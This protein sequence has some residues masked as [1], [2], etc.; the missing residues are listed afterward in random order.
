MF[1]EFLKIFSSRK[2]INGVGFLKNHSEIKE[3][4]FPATQVSSQ[5]EYLQYLDGSIAFL[6]VVL[7]I[8]AYQY[9]NNE[10]IIQ[11][12]I[13]ISVFG[14]IAIYY[15]TKLWRISNQPLAEDNNI[16]AVLMLNDSGKVIRQWDIHGKVSLLIGK[17]KK[18][19]DV[20]IDLS[21]SMYDA[22]IY[23]E[24]AVLNYARNNWYLEGLHVPSNVS[25]RKAGDQVR[26]RLTGS[27]PC[28]LASGDIIYI[29]NTRLM[30]K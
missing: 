19:K 7:C 16:S 8:F 27:K 18:N 24:H 15:S 25:I 2:R 6:A 22:L 29:A 26:Y 21:A 23:S 14:I 10:D 9:L 1:Q 12:F 5:R 13:I 30:I 20:D 3:F 11:K 17:N 4:D 28:K